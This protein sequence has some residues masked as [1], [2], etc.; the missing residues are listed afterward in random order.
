M[1]LEDSN[2]LV[3]GGAGFIGQNV[4]ARLL[5]E[6]P[7]M[8]YSLDNLSTGYA[9][10]ISKF[11]DVT[12]IVGDVHNRTQ[13]NTIDFEDGLDFIF[14]F[15]AP[16][17]VMQF[18]KNRE[19][20]I[21]ETVIGFMNILELAKKNDARL[22]YP[23]SGNVYGR[24]SPQ[25]EDVPPMPINDYARCKRICELLAKDNYPENSVGFRIFAGYGPGE[26]QKGNLSSVVTLFIKDMLN[27]NRPV[28][29]GDGEQTRDFVY[30][31]D[32]VEAMLIGAIDEKIKGVVNLGTGQSTSFNEL[33]SL[34]NKVF[35][36][37]LKPKYVDKPTDYVEKTKADTAL[38][39]K[40]FNYTPMSVEDGLF[41]YADYITLREDDW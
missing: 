28:I 24:A 13:V 1:K 19:Q 7:N 41:E 39:E 36:T 33:V 15:A 37:N 11:T 32:I 22:I 23:S 14:H 40:Y 17:S 2:I 21:N 20:S 35:N 16:C 25:S 3:T 5:H 27:D 30:I 8:I 29:W 31:D 10:S 6:K 38:F 26:N 18:K 12:E 34:L 9:P 4:V